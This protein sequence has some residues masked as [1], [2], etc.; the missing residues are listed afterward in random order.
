MKAR[1]PESEEEKAARLAGT[2]Q[3]LRLSSRG[4]ESSAPALPSPEALEQR[5]AARLKSAAPQP[6]LAE[7]VASKTAQDGWTVARSLI[8]GD[9]SHSDLTPQAMANLEAIIR[10]TGRPAWFVKSDAPETNEPGAMEAADA[11]W[12][13]HIIAA[14]NALLDVCARVCCIMLGDADPLA[15]VATGWLI[16]KN[17]IV[18]NAHVG[19]RIAR[20]NPALINNDSRRGWRLRSDRLGTVDFAFEHGS[21]KR[22]R[23]AIEEILYVEDEDHPDIAAF[24]LKVSP[25]GP[26]PPSAI[27]LDLQ[28]RS[29]WAQTRV[30]AAGHPIKDLSDDQNV[31]TVFGDIDGTKRFSPGYTLALLDGEV[32]THDCSTTNG[33]SGSPL[34]DFASLK[35][36]GLHYFGRPGARN[37]A[38]SLAAIASHPV[39]VNCQSG[40]WGI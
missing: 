33:N 22:S 9:L 8:E 26:Q 28:P 13:A 40:N 2:I 38:V 30:F 7:V 12:I 27:A 31:V 10:V 16:G 34:I 4:L 14:Q 24:R 39:I 25:G 6:A 20:Q 35:A 3:K 15:P 29:Q 1:F 21:K 5:I 17:T 23:F 37:E 19:A 11:F 36:V 32:L 18:T